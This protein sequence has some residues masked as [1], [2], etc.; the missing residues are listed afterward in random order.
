MLDYPFAYANHQISKFIDF[1]VFI[2]TPL[3]VALARRLVR[4]FGN[5]TITEVMSDMSNY[6]L[7]GRLAYLEALNTIRPQSDFVVDG[8]L[9]VSEIT[10]ILMECVD[11]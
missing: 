10:R 7:H 3:D 2:D 9:P 1:A 8:A 6:L 5:S 4:D 11:A